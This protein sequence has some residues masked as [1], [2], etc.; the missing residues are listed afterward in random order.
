VYISKLENRSKKKYTY[1]EDL[2]LK[3][4]FYVYIIC[5]INMQL[6]ICITRQ[7]LYCI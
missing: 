3:M 2:K 7:L 5:D 4:Y 6:L 1:I